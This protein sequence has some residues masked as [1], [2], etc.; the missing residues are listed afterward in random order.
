MSQSS[1]AYHRIGEKLANTQS[2]PATAAV[3]IAAA[4]A[5]AA[6]AAAAAAAAVAAAAATRKFN[7]C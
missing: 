6:V 1:P 2:L 4:A 5:V 3:D 7:G